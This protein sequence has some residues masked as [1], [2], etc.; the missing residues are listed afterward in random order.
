VANYTHCPKCNKDVEV[1]EVSIGTRGAETIIRC[2]ECGMVLA[3]RGGETTEQKQQPTATVLVV[4]YTPAQAD[5]LTAAFLRNRY[6]DEVLSCANGEEFLVMMTKL[7]RARKTPKLIV[8]E[9][10]M[11]IMN[12]INAALC[13]RSIEKGVSREKAPLLFF[14]Q[15]P[16]DD[17][18]IKAIKY[19]TPAKYVPQPS[20]SDIES[21][22]QRAD[23]IVDLLKKEPW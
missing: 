2:A 3:S 15:R 4:G 1:I 20:G 8:M 11:P 16:L 7:F 21:F 23:Q 13:M 19:L 9:V 5:I 17:Q 6:A 22:R 14:T 18:F 12:G 10:S